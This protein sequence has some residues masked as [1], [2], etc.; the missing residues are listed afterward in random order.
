MSRRTD[1]LQQLIA[2]DKFGEEKEQEQKFL[3]TTAE[4]ILT[5]LVNIAI[6]GVEKRGAGSLVINLMNDSTVFMSGE[7]VER[8]IVV[9]E[10]AEDDDVVAFLRKLLEEI[11]ENDW[12]KNVLITL[13]SDAG[14]RTFSLEAGGC[15]ESLR[16][17]AA[18]FSG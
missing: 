15:Q 8:D 4:L 16:T 6:G 3:A 1:L 5:D 14:T 13:I 17:I 7:D 11:D 2:S 10:S 12:S 9:A 18:E